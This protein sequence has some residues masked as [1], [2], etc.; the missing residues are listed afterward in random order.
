MREK[1]RHHS[2]GFALPAVV[3]FLMNAFGAWAVFFHSS[4]SVIR[5]EQ[6]RLER[7]T[8]TSWDAP[9]IAMAMRLLQSGMPPSDPY[10][11]KVALAQDSQTRF[12]LLTFEQTTLTRWTVTAAPTNADNSS[13]DA[14]ATF[15]AVPAAPTG[16]TATP[17]SNSEID[18]A[19]SDVAYDNGYLIE[20]SANGT[21]G[22]AQIGTAPKNAIAFINTGLATNTTY[23]YRVRGTNPEGDG[24]YGSIVNATTLPLPPAAPTGLT[25]VA[26]STTQIDVSW[27]DNAG[28]ELGFRIE[29]SADGSSWSQIA[30]VGANVTT[31]SA[32]GLT[33]N[34]SYFYRVRAYNAGGNSGYSNTANTATLAALPAA[35]SA[36]TATAATSAQ[37][38]LAWT[39]N[40]GNETGFKIERSPN[41]SSS[42]T[43]IATTGANVTTYTSTGLGANTAYYYRVRSYNGTGNS[44]Y[45]NSA[46]ATTLIAVPTAPTSLTVTAVSTS[47][48]NL[49]WVDNAT[50]ETGY[51]IER[52]G[53][54]T[55]WTQITTV[56][57]NV[58]SYSNTGLS[59]FTI[60]YYRVRA[61]NA[62]GDSA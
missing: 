11:C 15:A 1:R 29:G 59:T 49:A 46:N 23:Y 14:P 48:I 40:A 55:T 42:W 47:Q 61:Y 16:L 41:G 60:Y 31:Y 35:P 58:A 37:I 21:T 36:L 22:W 30:T 28:N 39:D 57:S 54:G 52:S 25:A 44:G 8:R 62:G 33:P 20:R 24:A 2:R 50:T 45:S 9:A 27:S 17:V 43:Q 26:A 13:P 7:E 19:W 56:G 10:S 3:L 32:T 6:A 18:L 4:S 5:I 34:T 38:N 51:K 53:D 12:V